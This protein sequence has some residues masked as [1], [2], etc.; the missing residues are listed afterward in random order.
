MDAFEISVGYRSLFPDLDSPEKQTLQQLSRRDLLR[1]AKDSFDA[2]LAEILRSTGE[3]HWKLEIRD[4]VANIAEALSCNDQDRY[5]SVRTALLHYY[6]ERYRRPSVQ[7]YRAY[8]RE[9]RAR[10]SS[11]P[12]ELM[13]AQEED[14]H[15]P[16]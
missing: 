2:N 16:A 7:E 9:K 5:E 14:S 1:I 11:T 6:S 3:W 4:V 13:V 8:L 10:Q 12:Q 15:H